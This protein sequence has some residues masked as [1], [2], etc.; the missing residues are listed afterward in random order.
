MA[1]N[2]LAVATSSFDTTTGLNWN[3]LVDFVQNG[4][5]KV[6]FGDT[7]AFVDAFKYWIILS[8]VASV[9]FAFA[10]SWFRFSNH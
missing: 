2:P 6:F 1:I 9:L 8:V 4:V 10:L 7:I 5:I 3:A